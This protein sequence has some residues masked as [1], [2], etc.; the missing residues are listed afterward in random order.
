MVGHFIMKTISS[1]WF[2]IAEG[3]KVPQRRDWLVASDTRDRTWKLPT[4]LSNP[5]VPGDRG[6]EAVMS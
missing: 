3:S 1:R 5:E 6:R 2:P 4:G